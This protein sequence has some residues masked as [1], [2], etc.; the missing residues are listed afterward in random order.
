MQRLRIYADEDGRSQWEGLTPEALN[1]YGNQV[2][3]SA[4]VEIVA[5]PAP[6]SHL[7]LE[8]AE[9]VVVL[10]GVH[11]Y[12]AAHETRRLFPGD[13]IVLD[14]AAGHGHTFE[15]IGKE[16]AISLRFRLGT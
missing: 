12:G 1:Q 15:A 11:E 10:C 6:N 4:R 2:A 8:R 14:D 9:L 3:G 16:A 7:R 5:A 13:M